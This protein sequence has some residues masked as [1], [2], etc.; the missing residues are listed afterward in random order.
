MR[1]KE[2]VR[3]SS[4]NSALNYQDLNLNQGLTHKL[5]NKCAFK[6]AGLPVPHSL[7]AS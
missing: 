2:V 6:L 4:C 5:C 3:C 1:I 7:R